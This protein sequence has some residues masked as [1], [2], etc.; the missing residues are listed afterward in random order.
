MCSSDLADA[1]MSV[2]DV[3]VSQ[4]EEAFRDLE[5]AAVARTV[6]ESNG[7]VSL[8]GGSV[9]RESTREVLS[10]CRVVWLRVSL[11]DAVNRV[12]MNTARPLLLGNVRG[13][14]GALLEQRTPV[15][16]EVATDVVDTSGRSVREVVDA[17]LEVVRRG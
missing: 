7:V 6:A 15:Y 2:S 1:G 14:L 3:F 8:G 16:E 4:G 12:G 17:V 10:G 13:T 5:A 11:S 9:L